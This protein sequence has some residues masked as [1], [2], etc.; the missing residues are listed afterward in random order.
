[1]C[2]FLLRRKPRIRL[3]HSADCHST[4]FLYN[5][6]LCVIARCLLS[7]EQ[8]PH[9]GR[10]CYLQRCNSVCFYCFQFLCISAI[11]FTYSIHFQ[12]TNIRQP[13][14]ALKKLLKWLLF[15]FLLS[16]RKWRGSAQCDSRTM[17]FRMEFIQCG[18]NLNCLF[19]LDLL[20]LLLVS[21]YS[22]LPVEVACTHSNGSLSYMT[23][24]IIK[25]ACKC[26]FFENYNLCVYS[27][28]RS[29]KRSCAGF[30]CRCGCYHLHL[31]ACYYWRCLNQL[32]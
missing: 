12:P 32:S 21:V 13:L 11:W 10:S 15:L 22:L 9:L 31:S 30:H 14:T 25:S 27:K 18:H 8:L 5:H 23:P 7:I 24:T 20:L 28:F 29:N 3:L 16:V 1:M 6:Q 4:T 19:T 2:R 26:L 17:C